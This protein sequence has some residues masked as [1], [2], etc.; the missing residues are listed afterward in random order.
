MDFE[1]ER[2]R[3]RERDR[4]IG[5]LTGRGPFW[6]SH[7]SLAS[8]EHYTWPTTTQSKE[9][10]EQGQEEREGGKEEWRGGRTAGKGWEEG[11]EGGNEGETDKE[12]ATV[13]QI[14][15]LMQLHL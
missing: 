15:Y 13:Q 14:N 12:R 11:R 1:R 4:T 8:F 3:E 2:E 6:L 5:C 9:P 10:T 7:F